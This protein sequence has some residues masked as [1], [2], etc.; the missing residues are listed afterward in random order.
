MPE[1]DDFRQVRVCSGRRVA[2][3]QDEAFPCPPSQVITGRERGTRWTQAGAATGASLRS[4]GQV[5]AQIDQ[6]M[7]LPVASDVASQ[8]PV[9][10]AFPDQ[11]TGDEC[12]GV[13]F[14]S[15]H[16]HPLVDPVLNQG[17]SRA[18]VM[19]SGDNANLIGRPGY[20]WSRCF[21]A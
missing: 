19:Q 15:A 4:P 3:D 21:G 17:L 5:L 13:A 11:Q 14:L 18:E 16:M 7:R 1:P 6:L 8:L 10:V 2:A 20:R 9:A 12:D